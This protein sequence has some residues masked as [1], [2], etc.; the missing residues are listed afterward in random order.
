MKSNPVKHPCGLKSAPGA[1]MRRALGL[2][3]AMV[4]STAVIST[5]FLNAQIT[6]V[7]ATDPSQVTEPLTPLSTAAPVAAAG[8]ATPLPEAQGLDVRVSLDLRNIEVTEAF[9]FLAQKGGFNM[10]V[11][12]NVS[13]R[14]QLLLN[15]VPIKD[16]LDLI[17]ITNS[18]A[19]EIR[20]NVYYI[21]TE[22]EYRERYGRKFSDTR[23]VR[24]F[25]L[26]YA[27]PDQAFSLLEI[28]KSDIGRLL[29]DPESGTV[30]VMDTPESIERM[31]RSLAG[32]EAKRSLKVY[33]LQYASALDVESQLQ[34]QLDN[35]KVG[36]VKADERTNQVIVETYPER[37]NE[38]EHI[39]TALD[40]KTREVLIDVKIVQVILDNDLDAE[41]KWE[42]IFSTMTQ[43]G[44]TFVSNH[45]FRALAREGL[46]YVDDFAAIAPTATPAQGTKDELTENLVL[47]TVAGRDAFEVLINFLRTLGET[48]V[49]SNPKLAVVNNEEAEILVG[50][51]QAYVTT[52]TTTGQTTTT[53]AETVTFVDVGI[54][55][56][57]T[58][59]I[60]SEG[61]VSM[62]IRP[63]VSSV[64]RFLVTPSGNRI[65]IIETSSAETAVMVKDG[66]SIAIGGLRKDEKKEDRRKVPVLG[67]IPLIGFVFNSFTQETTRTELLIL[68]TPHIVYGEQVEM[69]YEKERPGETPFMSYT[70]YAP[71]TPGVGKTEPVKGAAV[72]Q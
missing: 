21:M 40:Q 71:F 57:V 49:L 20:G 48:R 47:G 30:L 33:D 15:N 43:Y 7:D 24:V 6:E 45:P 12:K 54:Q 55:L 22:N 42:G 27:I 72:A 5:G 64:T 39:I 37:M 44:L 16:I 69:G 70:D 32:L 2:C 18:L 66:V 62:K 14:V 36:L 35:K 31:R 3:A 60:N 34:V 13:G 41:I 26:K 52:T 1:M 65:P 56:S 63:E 58:P 25:R 59:T 50:E 11:S 46:S 67:D 38:I 61:F 19:Y 17:I 28:L 8:D 68:I 10:V 23:I 29:V 9:R 4:L 51:K 53:T